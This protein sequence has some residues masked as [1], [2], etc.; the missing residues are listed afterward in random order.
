MTTKA[1][2]F[3]LDG[4]LS[5]TIPIVLR[6]FRETFNFFQI[7]YPGDAVIHPQIGRQI[8]HIFEAFF[9]KIEIPNVV[10][11]Y[12]EQY[13]I[14]QAET[15]PSL[16]PGVLEGLQNFSQTALP[17][18]IVTT[19]LRSFTLPLLQH[20]QIDPFF[21]VVIGAEDVEYC[22]PH[23]EPLLLAASKLGVFPEES[24]YVGDSLSDAQS[25]SA[26]HIPFF[27]VLTGVGEREELSNY[28]I[29]F[30]NLKECLL[31]FREN[32]NLSESR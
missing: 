31:F 16:F 9:P 3:D 12:R 23:P 15:P 22:K 11:V 21:S 6:S 25:A 26:A 24:I 5:D 20:F 1:I 10:N 18:G 19:K 14:A 29:V 4:T 17:L 27:G 8:E 13:L 7:P 32:H 30:Q 28:G 2:L